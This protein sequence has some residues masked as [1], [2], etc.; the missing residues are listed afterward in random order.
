K[1]LTLD[2]PLQASGVRS[3]RQCVT[4]IALLATTA[5]PLVAQTP[6]LK[7]GEGYVSVPGGRLW[8]RVVGTA[9]RTPL[10]VVHGCCGVGS[11]YLAPPAP[12]AE[13]R[14]VILFHHIGHRR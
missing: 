8:Y 5:A 6:E 14:A 12:P 4:L 2:P 1:C 3:M 13:A 9:R 10:L 11:Y 7:E